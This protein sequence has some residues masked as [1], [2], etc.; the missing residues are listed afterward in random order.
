[1]QNNEEKTK[2]YIK[3][4]E[5]LSRTAIALVEMPPSENIYRF[6][7]N[8]LRSMAGNAVVI[9]CSYSEAASD[10]KIEFISDIG[11]NINEIFKKAGIDIMGISYPVDDNSRESLF[12]AKLLRLEGGL[13]ALTCGKIPQNVCLLIER[14]AGI[15]EILVKGFVYNGRL[16]GKVAMI[17]REQTDPESLSIIETYINQAAV[18]LQRKKAEE[19][20]LSTQ[21]RCRLFFESAPDAYFITDM[22]G[23]ILECNQA[24]KRI[25]GYAKEDLLGKNIVEI[26]SVVLE[27]RTQLVENLVKNKDGKSSGPYEFIFR[28]QDGTEL[29]IE[30]RTFP[31]TMDSGKSV[32]WV[33]RDMTERRRFIDEIRKLAKFVYENPEPMLRVSI[34][35]KLMYANP[36]S[37][38]LLNELRCEMDKPVPKEWMPS[39][40]DSIEKTKKGMLEISVSD[41]LYLF[42]V[43]PIKEAGYVNLYG[44]DVTESKK[45]EKAL[46][47]SEEKYRTIFEE[48]KD[49][50]YI[51]TVGGKFVD[52]NPAGMQLFGYSSREE[53][54]GVDICMS[55]Y[56]DPADRQAILEECDGKGFVKDKEVVMK[57]K[58]G[59]LLNIL[60]TADAV[61]DEN[62]KM[63][64][65]RGILKDITERRKLEKQLLQSQKMESLGQLAGGI[66]HDFNN[67]LTNIIGNASFLKTKISNE[68]E[69]FE[70]IN[71]I[72]EG[73]KHAADLTSQLLAFA[74]GGKYNIEL[75]DLNEIVRRTLRIIA[76]TFTSSVSVDA[77][78]EKD[79]PCV[80]ADAGQMGQIIMN[81]CVNA[82]DAMPNGG[83]LKISVR[84]VKIDFEAV[85]ANLDA[86]QGEYAC[87]SVSDSGVGIDKVTIQRIFEPFF[88]TKELGR[89]TGLGLSVVYGIVKSHGGFIMVD[90]EINKGTTFE[91]YIPATEK[92]KT[93]VREKSG[94][95]LKGENELVL[96]VDDEKEILTLAKRILEANGYRALTAESGEKAVELFNAN[97]SDVRL[98]ILDMI[99]PRM[100]AMDIVNE[101]KK[102]EPDANIILSTGY[103]QGD[104]AGEFNEKGINTIIQKPYNVNELLVHVKKALKKFD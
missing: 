93:E 85:S 38:Q 98:V 44:S 5:F 13:H 41:R 89:G 69:I 82:R 40:A 28:K 3:Y 78:Y 58:D 31:M 1:M 35:G 96:I 54:E 46:R 8:Q 79:L 94:M 80:E 12:Q 34:E 57:R 87:I 49:V 52:I 83:V 50:I 88:T 84:K 4:L 43:I 48:S 71:T 59:A 25:T 23:K 18:A 15:K 36:C 6:I 20:L 21:E 51:S 14:M 56:A 33:A 74:R 11:D 101:L 22:E 92:K 63:V 65:L 90:S 102:I 53:I 39:I 19:D 7:G 81:L 42:E 73:A 70:F 24:V 47:E 55:L 61:R 100:D 9:V 86:K 75:V 29:I 104:K 30:L 60:V 26:I 27:H 32:L 77:E 37:I 2:N 67:I 16:F 64:R 99:M 97:K 45:A 103:S 68:N 17:F 10:L 62:G 95:E 66:S 72:E 76:R 91:I